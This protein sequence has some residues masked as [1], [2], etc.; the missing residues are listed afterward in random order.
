M[1]TN[2]NQSH[3]GGNPV[4]TSS[5]NLDIGTQRVVLATDQP[6][7]PVAATPVTQAD[8]FMLG[9]INVKEINGVTPLMGT[10]IMGTGSP[11]VTIASDN[12]PVTVKQATG[13]NLH[14]VADSGS[15]TAVTGTVTTKEAKAATNTTATVAASASTVTL[16]A[17]NANRL[18]G[19]I[20]N[21]STAI[22][23][24]KLGASAS[25]S[26]FTVVLQALTSSVGGYYEIPF[27]FT[28][29]ITAVWGSATGNA[30]VGEITT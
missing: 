28:G 30:R 26:D 29:I 7:V 4:S 15:T 27:G 16:I 5:G 6:V 8:T 14:M 19:T 17:S 13:T 18:G 20:Y 24:L 12:D 11:R 22:M 2:N 3:V 9:G 23:Y 10:G 25:T 1:I 21:D